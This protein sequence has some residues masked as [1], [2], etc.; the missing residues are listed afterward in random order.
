MNQI[1]IVVEQIFTVPKVE[2]WKAITEQEQMI[3]WF[4]ENI[5]AFEAKVGFQTKF[6]VEN[7]GRVF[8]HLWTITEVIQHQKIVYNWKYEGYLGDSTVS[9][10][11]IDQHQSTSLK[12]T[13]LVI[14]QFPEDIPEFRR[15]SCEAG[16]VYFIQTRLR[17]YLKS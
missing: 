6:I 11:L 10:E 17:E 5:E 12:L 9:F 15:E 3:Q 2:L 14:K 4:F 13:H 7:E 8:P 16:W 1:P